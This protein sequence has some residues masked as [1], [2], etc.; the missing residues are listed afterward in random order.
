VKCPSCSAEGP[1]EA[2]DCGVCCV[3]FAKWKAKVDK[4][5]FEAAALA[6]AARLHP[7][8]PPAAPASTLKL[9]LGAMACLCALVFAGYAVAHKAVEAPASAGALIRPD[10]YKP[11]I[12]AIEGG[13]YR[14]GEASRSD[15]K[16]IS[17]EATS[18]AGSVLERDRQ[19]PLVR[20]AVGDLM[21]FAGVVASAAEAAEMMPKARLDWARRW[22]LL[23][24][25]RFEKAPWLHA[26]ITPD[27]APP[28][29]FERAAARM[30]TVGHRLKT[31]LADLPGQLER[32]GKDDVGP[33]DVKRFGAPAR[34][35]VE[36]WAEWRLRWLGAVDQALL[37]FPRPDEIPSDLQAPYDK[38]VRAAQGALNPP[39]PGTGTPAAGSEAVYLP[40]KASRDEW[41]EAVGRALAELD[42]GIAAA[43]GAK[44]PQ[45]AS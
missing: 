44:T 12:Q 18:L 5:A 19:N 11:R 1:D 4:A 29:D 17:D 8:P 20:E 15:A 22:E 43:R 13:L 6:E 45:G 27:D 23:R 14:A 25:R 3:N 41:M 33:A 31:L 10:A 39:N 24:A 37:G 34:E 40:G 42:E 30:Q 35:K 21:E 2:A 26:A 36:K 16:L 28:P 32:F 9:T 7:P 38:L